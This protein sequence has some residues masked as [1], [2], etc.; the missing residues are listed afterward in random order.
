M[1]IE[2]ILKKAYDA[3]SDN[4]DCRISYDDKLT[5]NNHIDRLIDDG[6][7]DVKMRTIGYSI[8]VLTSSGVKHCEQLF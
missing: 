8:I 1:T 2:T 4:K 7:I 3:Y 6:L 5:D